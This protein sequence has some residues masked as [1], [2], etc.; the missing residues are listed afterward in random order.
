VTVGYA[1]DAAAE[2]RAGRP[3]R[4]FDYIEL[5]YGDAFRTGTADA[6][7]TSPYYGNRFPS[8]E[9]RRVRSS[10][11]T[12]SCPCGRSKRDARSSTNNWKHRR[13]RRE[14]ACNAEPDLLANQSASASRTGE[15]VIEA[16]RK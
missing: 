13:C 11:S 4:Y 15:I 10:S 16:E 9:T 3:E 8:S 14:T 2:I 1:G 7:Q 6:M 12:G 5:T